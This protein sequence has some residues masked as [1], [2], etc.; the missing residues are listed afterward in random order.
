MPDRASLLEPRMKS[1]PPL[2]ISF[3]TLSAALALSACGNDAPNAIQ[4]SSSN[5]TSADAAAVSKMPARTSPH[6]DPWFRQNVDVVGPIVS[7]GWVKSQTVRGVHLGM[8]VDEAIQLLT[9]N[10]VQTATA[11]RLPTTSG[12]PWTDRFVVMGFYSKEENS[13]DLAHAAIKSDSLREEVRIFG[14]SILGRSIVTGI[15]YSFDGKIGQSTILLRPTRTFL[16]TSRAD[17]D[18]TYLYSTDLKI[19][20]FSS[21]VF[22]DF[23]NNK[24]SGG[25]LD[26]NVVSC[27]TRPLPPAPFLYAQS[28]P[29]NRATIEI[30]DYR[31]GR[32]A[33]EEGE[34]QNDYVYRGLSTF[35]GRPAQ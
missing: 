8:P 26:R 18:P 1:Q 10:A 25:H 2:L 28:L 30:R 27:T 11:T 12:R 4:G 34:S 17:A 20:S 19:D 5:S 16:S 9:R 35:H 24:S 13:S 6:D 3:L 32:Q 21:L 22:F 29:R 7:A 15:D 23:C 33:V 31:I 14:S